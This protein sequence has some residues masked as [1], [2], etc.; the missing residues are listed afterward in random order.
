[1]SLTNEQIIEAIGQKTS[2]TRSG[3]HDAAFY[4][5]MWESIRRTGA[6][7]GEIWNSRKNGET[8]PEWLTITA[9]VGKDGK[10]TNYICGFFDI[11]ERKQ[12][13]D[14]IHNLTSALAGFAC[15][16]R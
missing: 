12:A 7:Q 13:E 4:A 9:V 11:T 10:I 14:K 3:H 8:Y 16:R 1:M 2:L 15:L 6:W 5:A